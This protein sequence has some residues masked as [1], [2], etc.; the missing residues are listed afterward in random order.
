MNPLEYQNKRRLHFFIF[1][2]M[3]NSTVSQKLLSGFSMFRYE[4]FTIEN[5]SRESGVL[6]P[7][8]GRNI[9]DHCWREGGET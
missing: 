5:P 3:M 8:K 7:I 4:T 9:K 1:Q 2:F 6:I